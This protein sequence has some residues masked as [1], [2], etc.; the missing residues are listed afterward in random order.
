[1]DIM[2]IMSQI[3]A[4]ATPDMITHPS[5][6]GSAVQHELITPSR[7]KRKRE[8]VKPKK[9]IIEDGSYYMLLLNRSTIL[10]NIACV[11]MLY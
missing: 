3:S 2:P 4:S 5:D 10:T 9:D 11:H 8:K 1:M 7:K 6:N